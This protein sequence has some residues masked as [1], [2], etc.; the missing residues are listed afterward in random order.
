MSSITVYFACA[1]EEFKDRRTKIEQRQGSKAAFAKEAF[2]NSH[3]KITLN[4]EEHFFGFQALAHRTDK[5][6]NFVQ[7]ENPQDRLFDH[8]GNPLPGGAYKAVAGTVVN[9]AHKTKDAYA[10]FQVTEA[11]A[12]KALSYARAIKAV[13]PPYRTVGSNCG[14]FVTQVANQADVDLAALAGRE[15][16]R[17]PVDILRMMRAVTRE[18]TRK[19]AD[20]WQGNLQGHEVTV[21]F[22]DPDIAPQPTPE[23]RTI[24]SCAVKVSTRPLK[25]EKR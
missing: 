23:P 2:G 3:I 21:G 16:I 15:K 4:G 24:A 5:N 17:L 20:T 11:E 14:S 22:N 9:G 1:D 13:P 8:T 7:P 19:S 12:R 6:G 25:C 18:L 10:E